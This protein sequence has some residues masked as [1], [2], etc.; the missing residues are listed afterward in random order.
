MDMERNA[1][2]YDKVSL[3]SGLA[4]LLGEQDSF[5]KQKTDKGIEVALG[6]GVS[7]SLQSKNHL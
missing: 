7:W 4:I 3:P 6:N 1:V 2:K 5:I